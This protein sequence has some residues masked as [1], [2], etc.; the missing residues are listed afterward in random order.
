[1]FHT[2]NPQNLKV[3]FLNMNTL[4]IIQYIILIF[5]KTLQV[6]HLHAKVARKERTCLTDS[7]SIPYSSVMNTGWK[8]VKIGKTMSKDRDK[9]FAGEISNIWLTDCIP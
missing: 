8:F 7:P 2:R 6:T 4:L 3:L 1:M 9:R 5:L